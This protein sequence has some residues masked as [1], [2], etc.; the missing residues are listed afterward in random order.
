MNRWLALAIAIVLGGLAALILTV[1]ITISLI[2]ILWMFVFG[3]DSWPAWVETALDLLT[4]PLALALWALLALL[5][6]HRLTR[7][8]RPAG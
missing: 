7:G 3:D 1:S 4:G 5:I 8:P 2:G 6:W